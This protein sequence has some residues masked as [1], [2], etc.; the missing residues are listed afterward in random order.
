MLVVRNFKDASDYYH[1]IETNEDIVCDAYD[2]ADELLA[3]N[4]AKEVNGIC[5]RVRDDVEDPKDWHG[6]VVV[7]YLI[8]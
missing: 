4:R 6:P 5:V 8:S 3:I 2:D 7:N 1:E